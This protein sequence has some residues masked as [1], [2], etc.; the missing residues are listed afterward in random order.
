MNPLSRF[1]GYMQSELR[2][3]HEDFPI[4]GWQKP[5]AD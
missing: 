1:I 3:K 4:L 5:V 2:P